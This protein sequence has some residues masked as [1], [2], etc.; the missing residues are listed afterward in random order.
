MQ[1]I[2][3][4]LHYG[5]KKMPIN[6]VIF[7]LDGTI[8]DTSEDI[9]HAFNLL[10]ER[11]GKAPV[12]LE[13][14]MPIIPQGTIFMIKYGFGEEANTDKLLKELHAIRQEHLM[15]HTKIY[16][17]IVETID[18]LQQENYK[19]AIVSNNYNKR[20][21]QI[22]KHFEIDNYFPIIVGQDEL[23]ILK[24]NP[25]PLLHA[26]KQLESNINE[27]FYIGDSIVDHKTAEAAKMK[28]ILAGY[29]DGDE[30][31]VKCKNIARH[32]ND[33]LNII[34]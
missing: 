19:L 2:S 14:F 27:C 23:G 11:Y 7:D 18:M 28:F 20:I 6:T 5:C 10:L 21:K 4:K 24:P 25:T 8:V 33:I 15:L 31:N 17:N 16:P 3:H 12:T 1:I 34:S 13:E 26:C 29:G 9:V 32:P 22:L 30:N